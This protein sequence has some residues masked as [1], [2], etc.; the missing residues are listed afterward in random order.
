MT[1][2][3]SLS[4]TPQLENWNGVSVLPRGRKVLGTPLRNLAHAEHETLVRSAGIAPA[5]PDWHSGILLL[6]DHFDSETDFHCQRGV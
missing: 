4:A 6:N 1:P 2:L 3:P 5:S